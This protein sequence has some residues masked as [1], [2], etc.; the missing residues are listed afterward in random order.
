MS[1]ILLGIALA[2]ASATAFATNNQNNGGTHCNGNGSCATTTNNNYNTTNEGGT[3][4][5]VGVG[6]GVGK[7]GDAT[8][9]GGAGGA[10]GTGGN[11]GN[12]T[13]KSVAIGGTG[14]A[15]SANA[16]QGS[17]SIGPI[18]G[19]FDVDFCR[20]LAITDGMRASGFSEKSQQRVLCQI[21]EV[22]DSAE[23]Q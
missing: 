3:G 9:A 22:K 6:V 23:C 18:G 16:C 1:R 2:L 5:G 13:Q 12:V 17:L 15:A 21:P 20:K 11:T 14:L 7:G 8:A 10:G 4:I 19:T